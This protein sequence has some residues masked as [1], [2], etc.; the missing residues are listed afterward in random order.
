MTRILRYILQV[1]KG[2]APC[3]DNGLVS[4]ATCKPKIRASAKAGEWV[5]GF[6][7]RP[8]DRGLLVWAGRVADILDVAE[9][10]RRY[11]GRSDAVYRAMAGGGF[12]R[13][14]PDYHPGED[15]F[16]KDTSA[17]VL[18]FDRE[19]TWYFGREPRMLP[20]SLMHLAAAGRGHRVSGVDDGD[21]A[22]LRAWLTS[23]GPPGVQGRPSDGSPIMRGRC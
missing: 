1:D 23:L 5:A 17:P 8:D 22:A 4:L 18:F 20:E 19:A 6:R 9:Y 11:R 3:V 10:E 21:A 13:L 2:M 12:K 7:P 16:R 15:E 14:R